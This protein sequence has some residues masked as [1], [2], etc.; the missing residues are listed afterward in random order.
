MSVRQS[1]P[2]TFTCAQGAS[3]ARAGDAR[4]DGACA[5]E[6]GEL[7]MTSRRLVLTAADPLVSA[8]SLAFCLSSWAKTDACAAPAGRFVQVAPGAATRSI[9]TLPGQGFGAGACLP[10]PPVRTGRTAVSP[11]ARGTSAHTWT[12]LP[13]AVS[14]S[15]WSGS[16]QIPLLVGLANAA[17]NVLRRMETRP[18]G[19]SLNSESLNRN[20]SLEWRA[21]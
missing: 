14:S 2:C 17:K 6:T 8:V 5:P 18:L 4:L 3:R 19:R 15:A 16:E 9:S 21:A 1:N 20:L 10:R 13:D 11:I 12:S 7:A